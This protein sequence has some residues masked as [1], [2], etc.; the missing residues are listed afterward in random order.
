MV[1]TGCTCKSGFDWKPPKSAQYLQDVPPP[2][3]HEMTPNTP[4]CHLKELSDQMRRFI[5]GFSAS[6]SDKMSKIPPLQWPRVHIESV[7]CPL[8]TLG[9]QGAA[10]LVDA[11]LHACPL[12]HRQ[13]S[14][15]RNNHW[16]N[17]VLIL[18]QFSVSKDGI[19]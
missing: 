14:W 17:T 6:L 11:Y 7:N 13:S 18:T 5:A 1:A 12:A 3:S 16:T 19:I 9:P 8:G 10:A 4:G 15:E 2:E